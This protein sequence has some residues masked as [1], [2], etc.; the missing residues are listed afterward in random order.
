[1]TFSL[2]IPVYNEAATLEKMWEELHRVAWPCAIE[3]ILVD[4]GST[5]GSREL[6]QAL[7]GPNDQVILQEK[8]RGKTAAIVRG[9]QVAKG[10][11]IAVQDAD[12]EYDPHDLPR[13]LRPMLDHKADA[14]YGSRFKQSGDQIQ[15]TYHRL[16]IKLL[17]GFSNL[18]TGIY[19]TDLEGCYKIWRADLIKNVVVESKGFDFDPEVT[20]KIAKLQVRMQEMHISY[21]PRAYFEGKKIRYRDGVSAVWTM[22]KYCFLKSQKKC[23]TDD[24]PQKYLRHR[25]VR[26]TTSKK[27]GVHQ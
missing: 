1:M 15:R 21:N 19:L 2:I 14:V 7:A 13:L 27:E 8:N 10:E 16:G 25:E 12:L 26:F 5:D 9:I 20:A 18:C 17:T 24:L 3:Y 23:F 22:V 4:D 6:I 11:F